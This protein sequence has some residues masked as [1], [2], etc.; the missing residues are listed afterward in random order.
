VLPGGVAI[1]IALFKALG[2]EE[3]RH[4]AGALREGVIYDLV[5]RIRHEDV[6][7][8]TI[9]EIEVRYHVDADQATRVAATA[10]A[11]LDQIEGEA[12]I[13]DPLARRMLEWSAR[14]HEIGLDIS[15]TGYHKHGAYLVTYSD[16][17][18]FAT[19][20]QLLLAALVR[21]HR[22]KIPIATFDEIPPP[23]RTEAFRLCLLL[24]LAVLLNRSRVSE[25]E[26]RLAVEPD[27]SRMSLSFP[28]GWVESHPLTLADLIQE[29][30]ILSAVGIDLVVNGRKSA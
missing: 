22:R 27:W 7:D 6:R 2:I 21:C 18:G 9:R 10:L 30:R 26:P 28:D 1:L 12:S 8:R 5:G 13:R 16:M 25:A 17:P 23:R 4:S 14:V 19:D 20:D 24:R 29:R 15:Y 3:M 11:L